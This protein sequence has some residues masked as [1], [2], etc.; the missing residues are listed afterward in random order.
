MTTLS[1]RRVLLRP[2]ESSDFVRWR[3]V[4]RRNDQW[5]TAWEPQR[6]PSQPDVVESSQ[7]FATRCA[8][9]QRERQL[10]TGYGLGLFVDEA[11][12]G[13]I[14][15][16]SI[17]RGAFQNAYVGYW[18]DEGLAGLGYVPEAFVVM[19][20][21]AF[22]NLHLHRIQAAIV[23]RNK[24]SRRVVEKLGLRDEGTARKYLEINGKWEDHVRYA[25]TAEDWAERGVDLIEEWIGPQP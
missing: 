14:N 12:V 3:D 11:F 18:I 5:L 7:A 24:S 6:L 9:R 13:E 8:S 21:F 15:L 16:N 4:R 25:M 22:E 20:R 17:Q 2:L 10:G 1:G 19:A 23:P